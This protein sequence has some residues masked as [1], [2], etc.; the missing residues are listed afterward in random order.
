MQP[1]TLDALAPC[2]FL[3][4]FFLSFLPCSCCLSPSASVCCCVAVQVAGRFIGA[5]SIDP[6]AIDAEAQAH[7][8]IYSSKARGAGG[9]PGSKHSEHNRSNTSEG[10]RSSGRST[11]VNSPV[12]V[13]APFL[14]RRVQTSIA[15][16]LREVRTPSPSPLLTRLGY[17]TSFCSPCYCRCTRFIP[18]FVTA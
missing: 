3:P 7:A 13:W 8:Q 15:P 4:S 2:S 10:E 17:L 11:S 18:C 9:K 6:A 16:S 1:T 5:A 14:E 12:S